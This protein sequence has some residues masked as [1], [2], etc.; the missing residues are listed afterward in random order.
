MLLTH[1]A[2]PMVATAEGPT[3]KCVPMRIPPM[4]PASDE[5][6]SLLLVAT[7]DLLPQSRLFLRPQLLTCR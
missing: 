7:Q 6:S 4:M 1:I 3:L 2:P 5:P